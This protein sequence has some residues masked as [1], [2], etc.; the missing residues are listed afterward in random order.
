MRIL[1]PPPAGVSPRR[2]HI[3]LQPGDKAKYAPERI[4]GGLNYLLVSE[5]KRI[6]P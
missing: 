4:P 6:R 2:M 5:I 3:M 1:Q